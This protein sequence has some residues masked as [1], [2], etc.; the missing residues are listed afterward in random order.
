MIDVRITQSK[1]YHEWLIVIEF[2][3]LWVQ[4]ASQKQWKLEQLDALQYGTKLGPVSASVQA[5]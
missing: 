2:D 4:S 5:L 3:S 1:Q